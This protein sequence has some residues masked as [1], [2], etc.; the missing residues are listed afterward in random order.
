M[1]T[2]TRNANKGNGLA[3]FFSHVVSRIVIKQETVLP[4]NVGFSPRCRNNS[5]DLIE[6]AIFQREIAVEDT[7]VKLPGPSTLNLF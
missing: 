1:V 5:V 2:R 3:T 4:I 7:G 6:Y